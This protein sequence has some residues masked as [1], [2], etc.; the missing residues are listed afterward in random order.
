M[1]QIAVLCVCALTLS[2]FGVLWPNQATAGQTFEED[3]FATS[4][5][6]LKIT[7]LGHG[8]LILAFGGKIIH[9]DPYSKTADYSALPKADAVLA[10]SIFHYREFTVVDAKRYLKERGVTVRL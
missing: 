6:E 5:G 10:A 7:F 2:V 1:N 8:S 9:V 3:V 4:A